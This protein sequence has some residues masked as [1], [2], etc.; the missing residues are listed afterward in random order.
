MRLYVKSKVCTDKPATVEALEANI[1][2]AIRP[3][4]LKKVTHNRA[5]RITILSNTNTI[6]NQIHFIVF[7]S[8]KVLQFLI[9]TPFILKYAYIILPTLKVYTEDYIGIYIYSY[10]ILHISRYSCHYIWRAISISA[11]YNFIYTGYTDIKYVAH[12]DVNLNLML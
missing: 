12:K 6:L 5:S 4:M 2:R 1:V 8:L 3:E 9:K 7:F 11:T 10:I